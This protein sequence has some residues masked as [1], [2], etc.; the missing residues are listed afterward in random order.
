MLACILND[1]FAKLGSIT[2]QSA[3]GTGRKGGGFGMVEG[4]QRVGRLNF[5]KSH[6]AARRLRPEGRACGTLINNSLGVRARGRFTKSTKTH[7][8]RPKQR[9]RR[10]LAAGTLFD[11]DGTDNT[12]EMLASGVS[13]N[14][15]RRLVG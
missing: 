11:F 5:I 6:A 13:P 9:A 12:A 2:L 4:A 3:P 8:K 1:I 7:L 10:W 15:S 14:G